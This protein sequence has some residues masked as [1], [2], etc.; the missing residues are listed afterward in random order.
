MDL[1]IRDKVARKMR[2][3]LK[4]SLKKL[5]R[6]PRSSNILHLWPRNVP[7]ETPDVSVATGRF[8]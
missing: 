5:E 6:P 3:Q 4:P 7:V 1:G 2:R 8:V